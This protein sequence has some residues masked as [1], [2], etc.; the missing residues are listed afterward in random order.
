MQP[1]LLEVC[2]YNAASCIIAEEAG[3]D[4]IEL[5]ADASVGG[6]TP[7]VETIKEVKEKV[8]I[9]VYAMVRPRGGDF[10]YNDEEIATIKRDIA[11]CWSLGCEGI[12]TGAATADGRIDTE[13]LKRIVD[14]AYPMRVTCHRVFDRTPDPFRAL[15]DIISCGCER[16]L[17]SGQQ[18]TAIEGEG[19]IAQLVEAAGGRIIIM[20]GS[21]VRSSNISE[22][23][24]A[25]NAR[26]FHSSARIA[27]SEMADEQDLRNTI[28]ILKSL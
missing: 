17:T 11:T 20:P 27:G 25:T 15:E 8:R 3:A 6:T 22:L 10:F 19:L 14:W 4:R 5:C 23:V 13:L 21:G 28:S 26:E 1:Y 12:A 18:N 2:A 9:P 7:S 24:S 16:I